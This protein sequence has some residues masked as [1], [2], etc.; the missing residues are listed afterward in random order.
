MEWEFAP[1]D[2]DFC[3]GRHSCTHFISLSYFATHSH[4]A[5]RHIQNL[6]NVAEC[7]TVLLCYVDIEEEI[8]LEEINK[9]CC[10]SQ[11]SLICGCTLEELARYIETIALYDSDRSLSIQDDILGW[12]TLTI[13][14]LMTIRGL[15]KQDAS[16]LCSSL[17]NFK[18][19]LYLSKQQAQ[20]IPGFGSKKTKSI[21]VVVQRP[22]FM[23]K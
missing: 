16:C 17:H 8:H 1:I 4:I 18:M 20:I 3:T 9:L 15:N 14:F 13:E 2:S 23:I 10:Q 7:K 21:E 11:V 19:L 5:M 6:F 22:F 12:H